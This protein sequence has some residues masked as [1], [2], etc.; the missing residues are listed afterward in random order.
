MGTV[1]SGHLEDHS[2]LTLDY[3]LRWDIEGWGH[4]IHN[5][6]T[7]FGP[8]TPNPEVNNIL[9]AQSI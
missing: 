6:W 7:E 9:G 5:R 4:E 8:N 2:R 1:H 3:G